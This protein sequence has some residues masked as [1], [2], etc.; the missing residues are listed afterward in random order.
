MLIRGTTF[1]HCASSQNWL[2][3]SCATEHFKTS[4]DGLE[5]KTPSALHHLPPAVS[6]LS[7]TYVIHHFW[8]YY[9]RRACSWI[10]AWHHSRWSTYQ[11]A[12]PYGSAISSPIRQV[13]SISP[14][15]PVYGDIKGVAMACGGDA[16]AA[17][18]TVPMTAGSDVRIY[19]GSWPH[20]VGPIVTYLGKYDGPCATTDPT[21]INFFKINQVVATKCQIGTVCAALPNVGAP[22]TSIGC[23]TP[24]DRDMR[25]AITGAT[26]K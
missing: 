2:Q 21:K 7:L 17:S 12:D 14:A 16:K 1:I 26:L 23:T 22:G 6:M 25:I 11:G 19:W 20:N 3:P 8:L 4:L 13:S 24:A 5:G 10:R 9:H 18:M 15:S